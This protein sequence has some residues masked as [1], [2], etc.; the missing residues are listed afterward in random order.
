MEGGLM[1]GSWK[2][3]AGG[4]ERALRAGRPQPSDELVERLSG[5][6]PARGRQW[7]RVSFA[8]ALTVLMLGTFVSFGGLSYAAAS[9]QH[10]ATAVKHVVVKTKHTYVVRTHSAAGDQ[11]DTV[12]TVTKVVKTVKTVKPHVAGAVAS[13]KPAVKSGT[14][15]FT[16]F[17]L[18]GTVVL[19]L[20]FVGLGVLLRRREARE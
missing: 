10:T 14:L 1:K 18:L 6:V 5:T 9:A 19:G 11:Y 15:P 2:G 12:K 13:V 8:S 4:V 7:S 20:G 3:D 16:G 17:S